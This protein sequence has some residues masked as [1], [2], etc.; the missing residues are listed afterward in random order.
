MNNR[1]SLIDIMID[2]KL[3]R[4][5]IADLLSVS[6]DVVEH[7]LISTESATGAAVPDMAIELLEIKLGV[8]TTETYIPE[9]AR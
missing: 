8:A 7:W 1:D 5:E 3:E 2:H 4:R 6:R 9:A